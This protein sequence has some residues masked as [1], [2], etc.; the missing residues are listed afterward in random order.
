[1]F[2]LDEYDTPF[3]SI[4]KNRSQDRR[5]REEIEKFLVAVLKGVFKEGSSD[6][7]V[8]FGIACG[9][10][11]I[12]ARGSLSE[13]TFDPYNMMNS[14]YF[15]FFGFHKKEIDKFVLPQNLNIQDEELLNIAKKW[16]NGN[17]SLK[18]LKSKK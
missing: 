5:E 3:T 1:M 2:I 17:H 4:I 16:Y 15:E 13:I 14:T 6:P 10:M 18:L 7:S 12:G 11:S 8:L 9:V